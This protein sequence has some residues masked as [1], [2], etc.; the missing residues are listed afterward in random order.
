MKKLEQKVNAL[1]KRIS[2]LENPPKFR[3]GDIVDVVDSEFSG[4]KVISSHYNDYHMTNY[5]IIDSGRGIH[6]S[7]RECRMNK[8]EIL[9][10]KEQSDD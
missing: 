4:G 10:T 3:Y 5:Y 6:Y 8:K 7:V 9:I 2:A 1:L